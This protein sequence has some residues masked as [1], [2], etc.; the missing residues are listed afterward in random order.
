MVKP[1]L[2]SVFTHA[3]HHLDTPDAT[4]IGMSEFDLSDASIA[5]CRG[6]G[7]G[8]IGQTTQRPGAIHGG[9]RGRR[10]VMPVL[11][12]SKMTTQHAAHTTRCTVHTTHYTLHTTA[13]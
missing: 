11:A 6:R 10:R 2:P 13:H 5:R 12:R 4:D 3:S 1:H 7:R 9:R 8:R